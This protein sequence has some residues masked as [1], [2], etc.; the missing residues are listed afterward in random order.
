MVAANAEQAVAFSLSP[1]NAGDGPEGRELL[2]KIKNNPHIQ[3]CDV[4]MDKAY[5]GD[6]TREKAFECNFNPVVPPK[7]NRVEPWQYDEDVYKQRNQVERLFRRIKRFRRVFT[8][9]DK[10][11]IMYTAFITFALIFD[12]LNLC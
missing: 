7:S 6:A 9:Y 8:R 3:F 12:L 4:L 10:T 1:G 2:E 11:D 5:E